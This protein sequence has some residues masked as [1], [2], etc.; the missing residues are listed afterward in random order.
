MDLIIQYKVKHGVYVKCKDSH[1]YLA[2]KGVEIVDN[3]SN[4]LSDAF[5]ENVR[6]M[7]TQSDANIVTR[8]LT[9]ANL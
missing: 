3:F 6:Q 4:H 1:K 5:S 9:A 2:D 8:L 7:L